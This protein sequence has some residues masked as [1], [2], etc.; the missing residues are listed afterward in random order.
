MYGAAVASSASVVRRLHFSNMLR[1]FA[2]VV[3]QSGGS[4]ALG[5]GVDGAVGG[6]ASAGSSPATAIAIANA[7]RS[8]EESPGNTTSNPRCS[9]EAMLDAA[10]SGNVS[11]KSGAAQTSPTYLCY[12]DQASMRCPHTSSV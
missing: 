2:A 6:A 7:S 1:T 3:F 8:V 10:G 11:G 4:A 12:R 5:G 9:A